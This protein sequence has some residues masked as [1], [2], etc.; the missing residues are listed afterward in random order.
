MDALLA[1]I[2][3]NRIPI[4]ILT[5]VIVAVLAI[6]GWRRRWDRGAR[7][8]PRASAAALVAVLAV[9]LPL[10][11]YMGSPL[12]IRTALIEAAPAAG[13]GSALVASPTAGA[14]AS[15]AVVATQQPAASPA[16]TVPARAL[17]GSFA[18]V[19]DF[20]FARGTA[21]LVETAPGRW[22]LRLED[23]AVR[24]GP[25][26]YVYLSTDPDG[27]SDGAIALGTLKATEGSFNYEVPSSVDISG[28]RSVV[29][30]C[31]AFSVPFGIANLT[32]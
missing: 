18:G 10:A 6:A 21:R 8:H 7:R 24:N 16:A 29:I 32:G 15:T 12:F 11:W 4:G 31:R 26:L 23:F 5:L 28:I 1:W 27:Y 17:A 3:P 14:G 13:A 25:D 2:Y 9:G 30:W 20:H 22:S 19:D